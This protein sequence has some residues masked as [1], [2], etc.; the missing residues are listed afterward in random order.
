[1]LGASFSS[2][3]FCWQVCEQDSKGLH[4]CFAIRGPVDRWYRGC[5]A[6]RT[7]LVER[8]YRAAHLLSLFV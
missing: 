1:M 8:F 2:L 3:G 7:V 4:A 5:G 6:V